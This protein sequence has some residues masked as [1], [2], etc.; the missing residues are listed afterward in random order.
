LSAQGEGRLLRDDPAA[1]QHGE[2]GEASR[3]VLPQE[4]PVERQRA[5]EREHLG[6]EPALS[7]RLGLRNDHFRSPPCSRLN[8]CREKPSSVMN[9]SAALWSNLSSVP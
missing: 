9:P 8:S 3:E 2:V 7:S 4:L 5:G 1:G 6:E